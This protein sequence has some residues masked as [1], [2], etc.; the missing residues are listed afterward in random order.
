MTWAY[1]VQNLIKLTRT[2]RFSRTKGGSVKIVDDYKIKQ[3]MEIV[4]PLATYGS[5]NKVDA[6]TLQFKDWGARLMVTTDAPGGFTATAKR[7][8][9]YSKISMQLHLERSGQVVMH[10]Q[11]APAR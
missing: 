7:I 3:P 2:M 10:F 6:K 8:D 5:G 9:G 11:E 1:D 4:E